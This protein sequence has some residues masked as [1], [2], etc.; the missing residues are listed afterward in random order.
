M[1][2]KIRIKL[3]HVDTDQK[4]YWLRKSGYCLE[5]GIRSMLHGSL[6]GRGVW[7]T[8][9]MCICIA[10]S[11]CC[12]PEIIIVLLTGCTPIQSLKKN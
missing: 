12:P 6:D 5:K 11:F 1:K 4:N 9:D 7:G 10:E 2:L 8:M 3:I